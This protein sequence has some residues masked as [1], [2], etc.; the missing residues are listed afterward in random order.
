M[1][2]G[3]DCTATEWPRTGFETDVSCL[4]SVRVRAVH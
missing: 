1:R 3:I 2:I 4:V